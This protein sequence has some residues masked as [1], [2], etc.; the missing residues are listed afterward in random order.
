M[1]RWEDWYLWKMTKAKEKELSGMIDAIQDY[2]PY[3]ENWNALFGVK[4]LPE[5]WGLTPESLAYR[6]ISYVN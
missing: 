1:Y 6:I 4:E 3:A 2:L 5:G